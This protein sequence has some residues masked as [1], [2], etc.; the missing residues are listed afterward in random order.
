[1]EPGSTNQPKGSG[2]ARLTRNNGGNDERTDEH[3]G[4]VK[5]S[6][7]AKNERTVGS[8]RLRDDGGRG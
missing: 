8:L 1:M 2:D 5:E 4:R 3:G 6:V 7:E